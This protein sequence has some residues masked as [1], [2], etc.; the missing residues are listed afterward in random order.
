MYI[1][2]VRLLIISSSPG[3]S[4][5]SEPEP[6]SQASGQTVA[7]LLVGIPVVRFVMCLYYRGIL[8][9]CGLTTTCDN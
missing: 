6:Q 4:I 1:Y 8:N 3:L 9:T 2:A 5:L 7:K